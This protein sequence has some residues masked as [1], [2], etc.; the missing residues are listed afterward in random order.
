MALDQLSIGSTLYTR[1]GDLE[2]FSC[3]RFGL[4]LL[5]RGVN[6]VTR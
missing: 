3:L 2:N 4:R 6:F 5:Q 1:F